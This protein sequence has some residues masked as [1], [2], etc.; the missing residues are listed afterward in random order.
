MDTK[1]QAKSFI[2]QAVEGEQRWFYGG[3]VHT[4][5]AKTEDTDGASLIYR[6]EMESGKVTPMHIHPDT[7]EALYI[8]SGE[9]LMN[10]DGV[11]QR[12]GAGGLVMALR[13]QPHAFK[14]T[15]EDTSVLCFQTPGNAQG[16]YMGASVPMGG[17]GSGVVDFDQIMES[18]KNNGGIVIVGP[19]PFD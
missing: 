11:E 13:G 4:W 17:E 15:A 6:D 2:R 16:F 3:G 7:D 19:P 14:V 5:L 18:G 10:L 9:I 8:L 12:V 1:K